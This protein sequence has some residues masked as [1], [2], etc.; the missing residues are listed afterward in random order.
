MKTSF[1]FCQVLVGFIDAR[2]ILL[3]RLGT[4]STDQMQQALQRDPF[5][6]S[7]LLSQRKTTRCSDAWNL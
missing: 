4:S 1:E 7:H 5:P 6:Q 2:C 3:H